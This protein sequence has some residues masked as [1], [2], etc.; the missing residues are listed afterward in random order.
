MMALLPRERKRVVICVPA[1]GDDADVVVE[2]WQQLSS[3]KATL[4]GDGR[5]FD[6]VAQNRLRR[7]A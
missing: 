2:R 5:T 6:V 1:G 7:A 4:E 3:K